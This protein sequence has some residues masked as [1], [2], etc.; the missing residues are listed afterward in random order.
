MSGTL[1]YRCQQKTLW[2][3]CAC[4]EEVAHFDGIAT[5][6]CQIAATMLGK[7]CCAKHYPYACLQTTANCNKPIAI[8]DLE[9][10]GDHI[11]GHTN[12]LTSHGDFL[13]EPELV[14]ELSTRKRPV[15]VALEFNNGGLGA[16]HLVTLTNFDGT[17]FCVHDPI[18]GENTH[19]Y[20]EL[21]NGVQNP[22]PA[23]LTWTTSGPCQIVP[24]AAIPP[25]DPATLA[26]IRATLATMRD[27]S[28]GL[29]RLGSNGP[30]ILPVWRLDGTLEELPPPGS[31]RA[32]LS[33][34]V[35]VATDVGYRGLV[36]DA[37]P[38]LELR[39]TLS[40]HNVRRL[41]MAIFDETRD[42]PN[43]EVLIPLYGV[44]ALLY[45][46]ADNAPLYQLSRG[47]RTLMEA[48][49]INEI[50]LRNLLAESG[51]VAGMVVPLEGM[52]TR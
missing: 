17:Y 49:S 16:L 37:T 42:P 34:D 22:G 9:P 35:L 46:D 19:T 27:G 1:I 38:Q 47:P 25:L 11:L 31:D 4:L 2:C 40:D 52:L 28:E 43:A 33:F 21:E 41:V 13:R 15:L 44:R 32:I 45:R 39:G 30:F 26:E 24:A 36:F 50:I 7:K 14:H 12:A 5:S 23:R 29:R 6:Q 51:M 18:A 48:G 3:W 10:L 8:T 20:A